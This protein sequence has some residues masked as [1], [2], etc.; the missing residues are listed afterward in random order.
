MIEKVNKT[1]IWFFERV[2]KMHNLW[3]GSP[4]R[5]DRAQTNRKRHVMRKA[6]PYR[7]RIFILMFQV[8]K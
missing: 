8:R 6:K 1:K 5:E 2:N 7:G 3:P 4:R